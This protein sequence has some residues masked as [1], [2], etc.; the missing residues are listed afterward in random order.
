[1]FSKNDF[2]HLWV[3]DKIDFPNPPFDG[4]NPQARNPEERR[5]RRAQEYGIARMLTRFG[6]GGG[7]IGDTVGMGKVTT[8]SQAT[9]NGHGLYC[10][11]VLPWMQ[12]PLTMPDN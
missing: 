6:S 12:H 1:M 8:P 9:L 3:K 10:H 7:V 5:L 11:V 4:F 2:A